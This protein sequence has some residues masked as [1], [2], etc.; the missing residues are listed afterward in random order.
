MARL[1]LQNFRHTLY[2]RRWRIALY[3][4]LVAITFTLE[5]T[6]E[7]AENEGR[8]MS[9]TARD[10]YLRASTFGYRKPD[11]RF[12]ALILLDDNAKS[13]H[14]PPEVALNG[15]Q[16]RLY[17]SK[18]AEAL[19]I[20]M[21]SAIVFDFYFEADC[22]EQDKQLADSISRTAKHIPIILGQDSEPVSAIRPKQPGRIGPGIDERDLV[23]EFPSLFGEVVGAKYGLVALI[24]DNRYIPLRWRT[25]NPAPSTDRLTIRGIQDGLGLAAASA[26]N[27]HLVAQPKL[28]EYLTTGGAPLTSFIPQGKFPK[29]NGLDLLCKDQNRSDW[30]NCKPQQDV[31]S[32][33][34]GQIAV[35]GFGD[36]EK[37][38]DMHDSVLGRVPGAVLQANYIESLLDERYLTQAWWSI[39]LLLSFICFAAIESVFEFIPNFWI[40]LLAAAGTVAVFYL[41][42]Y[43]TL[44]QFGC[45]LQLWVPTLLAFLLKLAGKLEAFVTE[46]VRN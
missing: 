43:F 2:Q 9:A 37:G 36:N 14:D 21:A 16:R 45:Y 29:Q 35:L 23:P 20:Q 10:L 39:E 8:P 5:R 4:V 7:R 18:L 22:P 41:V 33:F 28:R 24:A 25:A 17:L 3:F 42:S 19:E 6:G 30:Q 15:C 44:V 38:S 1:T 11:A 46:S 12:T 34:R 31:T 26:R 13:N 27:G 32:I 40:G